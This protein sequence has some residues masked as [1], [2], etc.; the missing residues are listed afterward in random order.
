MHTPPPPPACAQC[1]AP[2]TPPHSDA[3]QHKSLPDAY[4]HAHHHPRGGQ[5]L[6]PPDDTPPVDRAMPQQPPQP[7]SYTNTNTNTNANTDTR[8]PQTLAPPP[9]DWT[10]DWL[11]VSRARPESAQL[12]AEKTCEMICYLWF[13]PAIPSSTST[14]SSSLSA[15]PLSN[16]TTTAPTP[17]QLHASPTFVT[18]TQKL[19]ET[20]QLSQS[21]IVLALHYIFRL[22]ERNRAT[23]AQAGSEFRVA[24]AGLMMAN[25]FLDE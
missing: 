22:R 6:T 1:Y 3:V 4:L 7:A 14:P 21:A 12:V 25:K 5:L 20:T 11:H 13:A 9:L 19:L 15:A 24:V 16:G 10:H 2:M 17:L 23:P 18:F 8:A